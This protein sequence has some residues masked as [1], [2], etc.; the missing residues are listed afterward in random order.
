M[1]F[2]AVRY[3]LNRF[4]ASREFRVREKAVCAASL[5]VHTRRLAGPKAYGASQSSA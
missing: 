2:L 1:S 3:A 5:S 4:A